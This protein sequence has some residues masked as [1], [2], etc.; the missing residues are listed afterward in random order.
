MEEKRKSAKRSERRQGPSP[1]DIDR[2]MSPPGSSTVGDGGGGRDDDDDDEGRGTSYE[3][4]RRENMRRN[5]D[6]MEKLGVRSLVPK[7]PK[8]TKRKWE[9][10]RHEGPVRQS[11]RLRHVPPVTYELPRDYLEYDGDGGR[12]GK[13]RVVPRPPGEAKKVKVAPPPPSPDSCRALAI[14][15]AGW[16]DPNLVGT[17]LT[18]TNGLGPKAFVMARLKGPDGAG[19]LSPPR[20]SKYSGIQEWANAV[21]LFVNVSSKGGQLAYNN[22]FLDDYGRMTWFAQ[23]F[24]VEETP[25]VQRLIRLTSAKAEKGDEVPDPVL[26]FC[27]REGEPYVFGGKLSLSEFDPDARPLKFVWT[28]VGADGLRASEEFLEIVEGN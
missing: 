13:R 26:L 1:Q 27:R 25:V 24:H 6:R 7:S 14:D 10:A 12:R 9:R 19:R 16:S 3:E 2:S 22:L 18:P 23:R 28:L 21:C 20:F 17:L 4:L 15:K 5:R 11:A 8:K